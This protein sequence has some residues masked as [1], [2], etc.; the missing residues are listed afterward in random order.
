LIETK[1]KIFISSK[2]INLPIE[3]NEVYKIIKKTGVGPVETIKTTLAQNTDSFVACLQIRSTYRY[4]KNIQI[5]IVRV[6]D[7]YLYDIVNIVVLLIQ[8]K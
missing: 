6:T 8:C 4:Q 5:P 1:Q 7:L 3:R 2:T